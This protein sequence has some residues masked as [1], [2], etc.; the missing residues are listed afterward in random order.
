[1]NRNQPVYL[2]IVVPVTSMAGSLGKL[3]DWLSRINQ[4]PWEVILI[5]D[6]RDSDTSLELKM[7][8][9]KFHDLKIIL[10]EGE[11]GSPGIARN[12]GIDLSTGEWVTFWDCDDSPQIAEVK[13]IFS[14]NFE[15][16]TDVIVANYVEIDVSRNIQVE[17]KLSEKFLNELAKNPGLWRFVFRRS[18]ISSTR[19]SNLKMG[20]DQLFLVLLMKQKP[21]IISFPTHTYHY[22]NGRPGQQTKNKLALNDLNSAINYMLK[23]PN[24]NYNAEFNGIILL[25][26]IISGL[27]LSDLSIKLKILIKLFGIMLSPNNSNHRILWKGASYMS[28]S[29]LKR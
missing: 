10:F 25:K 29:V 21:K 1:M 7:I 13:K 8:V 17:H 9:E 5:H 4:S 3:T 18:F 14:N 15:S 6:Y 28:K 26:L 16:G 11:F 19:F 12:K 27:K 24:L 22:F 20:E 2:S 23:I